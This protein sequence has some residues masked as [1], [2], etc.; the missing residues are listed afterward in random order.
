MGDKK[1]YFYDSVLSVDIKD[2]EGNFGRIMKRYGTSE[3]LMFSQGVN[4]E[5]IVKELWLARCIDN[6]QSLEDIHQS[7]L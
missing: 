6:K 2:K 4:M 7:Y 5:F 1:L 3:E